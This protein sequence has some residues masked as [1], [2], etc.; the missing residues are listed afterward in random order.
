MACTN[1]NGSN[2][3]ED[4]LIYGRTTDSV[5][6]D[7]H[8]AVDAES[9]RLT[10]NFYESLV[11]ASSEDNK[12][13]PKLA[14]DWNVSE[15]G[16]VWTFELREGVK[17]HDGTEL[18]AEAV[19]YN[20]E[21]MSD[22]NHPQHKGAFSYYK[23]LLGTKIK[24]V[25]AEDKHTVVFQLHESSATFLPN[26][27]TPSFGIISP[28]ALEEH[29]EEIASNP[30]GTGPFT[31]DSWKKDS[32]I[33]LEKNEEYWNEGL[34]KLDKVI[35]KVIPDNSARLTALKNGEIDIM[36]SLNTSDIESVKSDDRL[37][38]NTRPAG[39]IGY[40]SLNREMEPLDNPKVRQ[41][42]NHAIDRQGIADAF[43]GGQAEVASTMLPSTSWAFNSEIKGYEYNPEKAKELLAEAGYSD[44]FE[45]E[46]STMSD[47]RLWMLQPQKIAEVVQENLEEIGITAKVNSSEWATHVEQVNNLKHDMAVMG[48]ITQNGDPSNILETLFHSANAEAPVAANNS[49][50]KNDKVDELFKK[51]EVTLEQEEREKY[52]KEIQKIIHE[53]APTVPMVYVE[54]AMAHA[55]YV[56]GLNLTAQGYESIEEVYIED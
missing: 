10:F 6:L 16:T 55:K 5:S 25:K 18:D 1:E 53:D 11:G 21:R 12:I 3:S 30:V 34:P 31:F 22:E 24:E 51:A 32:E 26:L 17:F 49:A 9:F 39:N 8:N 43:F 42:I 45:L 36:E 47:P 33:T 19:V 46:Y 40:I 7:P 44:G 37:K 4:I 20:F 29:G 27:A 28:T 13:V 50:F 15:D 41:A 2:S 52:Y 48:W 54:A 23:R 56:K 14:E 35:Y 38:F